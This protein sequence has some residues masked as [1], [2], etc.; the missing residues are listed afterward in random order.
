MERHG[1]PTASILCPSRPAAWNTHGH[2]HTHTHTQT[3]TKKVAVIGTAAVLSYFGVEW[4]M[5]V[6]YTV[7]YLREPFA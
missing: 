4:P 5:H 7:G 2:S 1:R 6:R 3:N